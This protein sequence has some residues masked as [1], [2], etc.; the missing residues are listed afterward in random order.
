MKLTLKDCLNLDALTDATL[1]SAKDRVRNSV[2]SVSVLDDASVEEAIKSNGVKERLVLTSFSALK[3]KISAQVEIVKKLAAAKVSGLV[4][5]GEADSKLVDAAENAGLPL[6][7][8]PKE[9]EISYGEIIEQVMEKILVGDEITTS[10]INNTIFHL[11]D[12]D[13][14]RTFPQAIKKAAI[15][16]DF[17]AVLVSKDF[18]PV[19][20]VETRHHVTVLDAVRTLQKRAE[21]DE[22]GI[23]SILDVE[24]IAAYWGTISI[25]GDDY[26]LL[27]VD[28]DD[29]YS[30][31]DI[32][33]LAEVIE[34]AIGMWKYSP[35]RD[36]KAELIKALMRGNKSLAYTLQGEMEIDAGDISSVF[37]AKGI[38]NKTSTEIIQKFEKETGSEVLS[39]TE[40]EET[41]GLIIDEKGSSSALSLYDS[42]KE[43]SKDIRI[44]HATGIY[45]LESAAESFGLIGETWNFVDSVFPY[46]R[47]FSKYELVLVSD[48]I[49]IQVHGGHMKKTYASLLEPFKKERGEIKGKQLLDTLETFVLDAGMNGNKTSQYM[50]IHANTVQY[51][52]KKINEM[53]GVEITGNRVIP[54]LTIALALKR[55]EGDSKEK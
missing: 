16:N 38:N 32:T 8:I 31:V 26:F 4:L 6:I 51:R 9:K 34:L 21:A 20:V 39:I 43:Q 12:F 42:L 14:N 33:K 55:L 25:N 27:L 23:Y 47:V 36:Q 22:R 13:R 54:G 7:A 45:G 50:G 44:Y 41:Y 5:M 37:F 18:N 46:K 10:L 2:R 53:L 15:S 52:L 30:A 28:N 24:G 17:Q 11:L 48:C 35:E 29:K 19:L 1:V 49:N 40:D 3:N